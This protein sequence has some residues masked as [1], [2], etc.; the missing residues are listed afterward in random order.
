MRCFLYKISTITDK[1]EVV[2]DKNQMVSM[3]SIRTINEYLGC[4]LLSSIV[5]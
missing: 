2:M 3:I 1:N 4:F 5:N